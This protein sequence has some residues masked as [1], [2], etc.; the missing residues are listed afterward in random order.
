MDAEK[1]QQIALFRFSIIGP[2]LNRQWEHG[3]IGEEISRMSMQA[4]RIPESER[5]RIGKGTILEWLTRYK[6]QG[7]DGLLPKGR[8][9]KGKLRKIPET[10]LEK[11]VAAKREN[12]RRA[13]SLICHDLY[14]KGD[15]STP[16]LPVS[17]IYR[18]LSTLPMRQPDD[19][20]EQKRYE[21]RFA[22]EMWQSDV[23]HG[24]YLPH[25]EGEK[26][27]KT[28]LF[29][30]LDDA[31]R[32]IVGAAFHPTEKLLHLKH[33]F[34]YAVTTYGIPTKF[35]VDNGK[36]FKAHEMEI[37]CAKIG[38]TLIYA[39]PYYPEGKGKIERF[40]RS[41]RDRFLTGIKGV[42]SLSALNQAFRAWLVDDYNQKPHN[43]INQEAPLKRYLRL[44]ANIRR[45]P[46]DVHIE[47]LFYQN[48]KRLV[49]KDSTF[50]IHN[51]LYE[52]PEHLIGRTIDVFF[53]SDQMERVS[54]VYEGKSEGYCKPIDFLANANI[55]RKPMNYNSIN[56]TTQES[57]EDDDDTCNIL[58]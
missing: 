41:V 21:C 36:I 39:T 56:P 46:K 48:V 4:Y 15:L 49:S 44:D 16:T 11:V 5:H 58:A 1:R 8:S 52:A 35:Y 33:V 54:V 29:A 25:H 57:K 12:P 10:I 37:A 31:S 7:F 24:P 19:R 6:R 14:K 23:M 18:Y 27:R 17:T 38:T 55:K 30:I 43:G 13:V 45:L 26:A 3:E 51:I 28:Y 42:K 53:D 2:L 34:R 50:R 32:L 47:E 9:D 20:K 22:N 40:F